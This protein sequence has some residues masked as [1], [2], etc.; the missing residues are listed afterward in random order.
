[1][2]LRGVKVKRV[3]GSEGSRGLKG[4]QVGKSEGSKCV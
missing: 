1:M 2:D 3:C 4:I